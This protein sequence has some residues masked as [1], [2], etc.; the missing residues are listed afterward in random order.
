MI[1]TT[2]NPIQ[3]AMENNPILYR[4]EIKSTRYLPKGWYFFFP[5]LSPPP[6]PRPRF[7]A[8]ADG[9]QAHSPQ[10]GRAAR[11]HTSPQ[12][13]AAKRQLCLSLRWRA[14]LHK[15][16]LGRAP[17]SL[18]CAPPPAS[19][20]WSPGNCPAPIFVRAEPQLSTNA[21]FWGSPFKLSN[22]LASPNRSRYAATLFKPTVAR[23]PPQVGVWEG[24]LIPTMRPASGIQAVVARQL[25]GS[26]LRAG[27]AADVPSDEIFLGSP[28]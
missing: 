19:K 5:I 26:H 17:L 12:S 3:C 16:A 28:I 8:A 14:Y 22:T 20:R 24:A 9:G 1:T 23:L 27:G 21:Q 2:T 4:K 18:Q 6:T 11:G 10:V 13:G 25:S 7:D 15:W